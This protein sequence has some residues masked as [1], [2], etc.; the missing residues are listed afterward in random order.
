[1]G[2]FVSDVVYLGTDD[3]FWARVLFWLLAAGLVM[4]ALA[5]LA[6]FTDF[7]GDRLVRATRVAWFHMIGNVTAVVLSLINLWLR[8]QNGDAAYP[9]VFWISLVVVLIFVVT[10]WLGGELVFHHRVGVAEE[11][12]PA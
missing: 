6:G 11:R 12:P 4:G 1:V 3:G 9:G 8:Y 2:T 10:G 5:A 7:L